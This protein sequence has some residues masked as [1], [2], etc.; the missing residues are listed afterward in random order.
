MPRPKGPKRIAPINEIEYMVVSREGG[1]E[2]TVEEVLDRKLYTPRN[3]Q[4]YRQKLIVVAMSNGWGRKQKCLQRFIKLTVNFYQ[5]QPN[6][7]DMPLLIDAVVSAY[8]GLIWRRR[9]QVAQITT[10]RFMTKD[11]PRTEI[12]IEEVD[13]TPIEE[14]H[15]PTD[16]ELSHTEASLSEQSSLPDSI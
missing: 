14:L 11:D 2:M 7:K 10:E 13:P 9:S 12:V 4:M 15:D 3:T 16:D 5:T 1:G 6:P 8:A